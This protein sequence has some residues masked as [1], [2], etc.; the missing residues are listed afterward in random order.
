MKI[1][2]LSKKTGASIRSIRHYEKKNLITSTR[3]D[4]G[5]REFDE[6]SIER[7]KTIKIYLGLGL[8]TDQIE[9]FLNCM[10]S[11]PQYEIEECDEVFD[12]YEE[13][14]AEINKNMHALSIV[15][16]RL[17][18]Q[19]KKKEDRELTRSMRCP[20]SIHHH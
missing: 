20:A 16:Q 13:K 14:L 9:E 10:D 8:T 11:Y 3:L 18:E 17:E 19:I 7:I 4:N 1:S 12:V 2:E 15:K 5:Y 6:S